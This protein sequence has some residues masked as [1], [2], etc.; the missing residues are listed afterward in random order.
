MAT[1]NPVSVVRGGLSRLG[2]A[3]I[4]VAVLIAA[5]VTGCGIEIVDTGHRGVRTRFGQVEAQSLP[6]GLYF[7]N[8]LTSHIIEMDARIQKIEGNTPSYTKD[9]QQADV[10]YAL[11]FRLNPE[12]AH[13]LYQQVGLDWSQKLI[14]QVVT[15]EIKRV[16]GQYEAVEVISKRDEVARSNSFA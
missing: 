4:V 13:L 10:H 14:A 9:V 12:S 8:P 2:I 3:A 1:I 15:E 7:Y 6:E 16:L 11:N 5:A